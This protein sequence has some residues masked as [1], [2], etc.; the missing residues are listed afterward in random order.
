M[1]SRLL[2]FASFA[3][4]LAAQPAAPVVAA[5]ENNYSYIFPGLPNYGIAQGSIFT[6]FG[7][8]LAAAPSGLQGLPLHTSLDGVSVA[9]SVN[10]ITTQALL[11]Y[12]SPSQ[13]GGILPSATPFGSGQ[14][15]VTSEGQTSAPA[16]ILVVQT[17]F[18]ILSTGGPLS[19]ALAFDSL[20][21]PLSSTNAANPG[22]VVTFYGSG[23][24]PVP[25]DESIQQ[26]PRNLDN[27]PI[28]VDIGGIPASVNYHGRT[29]YPGLDQLNVVIP[30]GTVGCS[31]SVAV[32]SEGLVSNAASIPIAAQGRICSDVVPGVVLPAAGTLSGKSEGT[33]GAVEI[34]RTAQ[35]APALVSDGVSEPA[36]NGVIELGNAEFQNVTNA[37]P[38][39][40]FS[41]GF[42]GIGL[43]SPGSCSVQTTQFFSSATP[44][45]SDAGAL[46]LPVKLS[47]GPALNFTGPNGKQSVPFLSSPGMYNGT[48]GG[49]LATPPLP[50]FIPTGGGPL[51]IDNGPGSSA[52]GSFVAQINA[53]TPL[54]WSNLSAMPSAIDRSKNLTVTWTGGDPTGVVSVSANVSVTLP[55]QVIIVTVMCM[56]PASADQFTIPASA[57]L[58]LPPAATGNLLITTGY[59]FPFSAPNMDAGLIA[60][61]DESSLTVAFQ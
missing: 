46:P 11:Y 56:V 50:P 13:V 31:V 37:A 29:I 61:Q 53:Y 60:V 33:I 34:L 30:A 5:V 36:R 22:D 16:S 40:T 43:V 1:R 38:T 15:T 10:G 26:T 14:M 52:I 47:A 3:A 41:A 17:A 12:V 20:G 4:L 7:T 59:N 58:A 18:G 6:I 54:V 39:F 24:G 21:N 45:T 28:E 49:S 48:I 9:I 27:I 57:L 19:R 51:T 2:L 44:D 23:A 32:V 55:A 42:N 35:V 8:N 25:G